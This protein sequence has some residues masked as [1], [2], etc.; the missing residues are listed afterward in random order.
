[1]KSS[2]RE[3]HWVLG[4]P[5]VER[6]RLRW[7]AGPRA[8]SAGRGLGVQSTESLYPKEHE[9]RAQAPQTER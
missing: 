9:P 6:A 8:W 4:Q 1:M 2:V 5:A 7:L 3:G